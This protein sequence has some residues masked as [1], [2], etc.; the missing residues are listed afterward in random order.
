MQNLPGWMVLW[1]CLSALV[2]ICAQAASVLPLVTALTLLAGKRENPRLCHLCCREMV[3]LNLILA[4]LGPVQLISDVSFQLSLVHGAI[5]LPENFTPWMPVMLPYS[6]ALAAWLA[7]IACLYIQLLVSRPAGDA[8]PALSVSNIRMSRTI[9]WG[10]FAV[11]LCFFAAQALPSCPFAGLPEG[12]TLTRAFVAIVSATLHAFF[13]Y[14]TPAGAIALCFF[15]RREDLLQ[16]WGCTEKD[17]LQGARWFSLWA[18]VGYIPYCLDRWGVSLGFALRPGG[19]PPAILARV[20]SLTMLTLAV[21]CWV[22]LFYRR[23]SRKL[24]WLNSLGLLLL[25]LGEI[26]PLISFPWCI[27]CNGP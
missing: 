8:N 7:G 20:P 9:I 16:D 12:L 17:E 22:I 4:L 14:L 19:M 26:L 5:R 2:R 3:R 24:Y 10:G 11:V 13:S 18:M 6:S 21:L 1:Q 25:T 15:S 27:S 23:S